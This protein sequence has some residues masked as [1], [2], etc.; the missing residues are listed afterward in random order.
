M[1]GDDE[2][3]DESTRPISSLDD[4]SLDL[5]YPLLPGQQQ[6]LNFILNQRPSDMN[7]HTNDSQPP[8][9][10]DDDTP[11]AN[12][13]V[14]S[15]LPTSLK[16][17]THHPCDDCPDGWKFDDD[18]N[19]DD[20]TTIDNSSDALQPPIEDNPPNDAIFSSVSPPLQSFDLKHPHHPCVC[21]DGW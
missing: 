19:T 7:N 13:P 12:I 15:S 8:I 18:I 2:P 4:Y 1:G 9:S 20:I 6:L 11:N 16:H 5:T 14:F 21:P 10:V 3:D 17:H